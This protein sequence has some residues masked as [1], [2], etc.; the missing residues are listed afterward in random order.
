[1]ERT[2]QTPDSKEQSRGN[3][4]SPLSVW[5][6]SFGCAVGWGA[7]VMPGTTFLPAAGPAG[8]AIGMLIGA[9]VMWIIGVNYHYL[10]NR[11]P[12]A[13]GT[14]TYTIRSFGYDH[15]FLSA[16]F[17]ILVYIAIIWANATAL[18]L[19]ARSLW[20]NMFQFG[21][22]YSVLGYDVYFGEVLLTLAAILITGFI[23]AYN[24][25][26][27]VGMQVLFSL[28]LFTLVALSAILIFTKAGMPDLSASPF[29]SS[30]G[31]RSRQIFI[32]VALSPWAFAGFESVSN[33]A[34]GFHFDR[35]RT[36]W[37]FTTALITGALTYIFLVLLA[38]GRR[39]NGFS[40]WE[41]YVG[42]LDRMDSVAAI[43]TFYAALDTL[44]QKGVLLL[45]IAAVSGIITGLVGNYIAGS[46]LLYAMAREEILPKYFMK[47]DKK[48]N[49]VN[50]ILFLMGISLVI[51][52][53]GRTA[54]G[55]IIDVNT[56]GA[57]IAYAYTSVDAFACA[58]K[59]KNRK[60]LP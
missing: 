48:A 60:I 30:G 23:C 43:P 2:G 28:L 41:Q 10:I 55:W 19:I 39:P 56:V 38:A 4:L 18:S 27:A 26:L 9:F 59:E 46:R 20:G 1:M 35:K 13:G 49:P 21:F 58:W 36:I 14:L 53:L 52:F 16:W 50:A 47:L 44:G 45:T 51:P 32:I 31:A 11:Y 22:M 37:I 24:K 33:S 3:Y 25:R 34:A 15:G 29:S 8:S 54:I 42:N 17:L 40:D 57:T 5:A 12:D 7:F 6:L